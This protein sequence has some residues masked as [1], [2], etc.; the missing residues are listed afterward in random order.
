MA[1]TDLPGIWR[2]SSYSGTNG[3]CVEA[4]ASGLAVSVRDSK[5]PEGPRLVFRNAAWL[6][7]A[8]ELK[9]GGRANG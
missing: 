9:A 8:A 7:F 3:E 2:R 5:D 4:A 1:E 6:T